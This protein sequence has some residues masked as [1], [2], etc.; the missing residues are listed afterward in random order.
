MATRTQIKWR[1]YR[2]KLTQAELVITLENLSEFMRF[3]IENRVVNIYSFLEND[4]VTKLGMAHKGGLLIT[5]SNG[6]STLTD[7]KEASE[8]GFEQASSY[9]DAKEQGFASVDAYNLS[10]ETDMNDPETFKAM[11]QG[12][13]V[14]GFEEYEQALEGGKLK[15][16]FP[17][18]SNAY[19]LYSASKNAGFSSWFELL[20]A[21]E[22]GF[23]EAGNYRSATEL[24]YADAAAYHN[25]QEGGFLHGI[26]W[27]EAKEIGCTSRK[28]LRSKIDLDKMDANGL[29][30]DARVLVR[31]LSKLPQEKLVPVNKLQ[32]LLEQELSL[33]QDNDTKQFRNWFTHQLRD[34]KSIISFLRKEE[35][36]KAFGAYQHD[37]E[38][39]KTHAIENRMVVLDGSNVAHNSK[40]RGDSTP[41]V[42][43][44]K[45]MVQHLHN[46]GF[47]N[48]HIITDASLKHKIDDLKALEEFAE[49]ND[50]YQSAPNTSADVDVINYVK[51]FN[52]LMVSNDRFREWK[53]SDPWIEDNIDYYRLT[54]NIE[55]N[56]VLMKGLGD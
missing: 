44:L 11:Q 7:Y 38:A 29:K 23:V 25:G 27:N 45:L 13:Y 50:Y 1:H 8:Q 32:K 22:K 9:Y 39:F 5:E 3:A 49:A 43:N 56:K 17:D 21:L 37:R 28:E 2:A 18:I 35:S 48:I 41:T 40:G 46:K 14:E 47:K 20:P 36:V 42:K 31:M 4:T 26:E 53:V 15:G 55:G 6:Y 19:D 24:G 12:H 34:L 33:F 10:K 54:F 30:H 51:R 16:S 52:C